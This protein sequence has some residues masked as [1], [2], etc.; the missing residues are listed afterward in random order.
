[1]RITGG[2]CKSVKIKSP[3]GSS[4][5][6]TSDKVREALFNI[7]GPQITGSLFVDGFAGSGVVGI[8]A[9]S[10]GAEY[11]Y[12][13]E[14]NKAWTKLIGDN[15]RKTGVEKKAVIINREIS[16]GFRKIAGEGRAVDYV[17]LDPPYN[18]FLH[19][20]ACEEIFCQGL[21]KKEGVL[22]LEHDS[23]TKVLLDN[24]HLID[25][26]WYGD[27]GLSLLQQKT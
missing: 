19:L 24:W 7:L 9:L 2:S 13:I 22:I 25:Q 4:V 21:L 3:R 5:R 6:P 8:E 23:R 15:L 27:T 11:C 10:R 26:R 17:F 14:Q 1:M 18:S 20:K 12:F 16:R